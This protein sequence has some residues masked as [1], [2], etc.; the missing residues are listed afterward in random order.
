LYHARRRRIDPVLFEI[1]RQRIEHGFWIERFEGN[2]LFLKKSLQLLCAIEPL[3]RRLYERPS[4]VKG[5]FEVFLLID[6]VQEIPYVK[7]GVPVEGRVDEGEGNDPV[8]DQFFEKRFDIRF[9]LPA[10][11]TEIV[12]VQPNYGFAVAKRRHDCFGT[13]ALYRRDLQESQQQKESA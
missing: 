1:A 3:F 8:S 6:G 11:G 13:A 4:N 12:R 5:V 2:L 10:G 7:G 9:H